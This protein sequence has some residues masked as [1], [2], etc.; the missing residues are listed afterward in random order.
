LLLASLAP[1]AAAKTVYIRDTLYVPLRG[2]QSPEYRILHK[3]IKSGT[4]LEL[5]ETNEESKYSRVRMKDGV[6]GWIETQYLVDEPIARDELVATRAQLED[7]Q[8]RQQKD[9]LRIQDLQSEREQMAKELESTRSDLDSTREEL[10]RIRQLSANV[11]QIDEKNAELMTERDQLEQ[12][13]DDLLVANDKLQ[14]TSNQLWFMR[15][16]AVMLAAL[17]LGLWIGRRIY[18]RRDSGWA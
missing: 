7:L 8:A 2:G 17:L 14:D 4:P 11:I 10:E 1:A 16:G 13:I 15:G 3:G 18:H 9:L 6:E 12:H 5:L